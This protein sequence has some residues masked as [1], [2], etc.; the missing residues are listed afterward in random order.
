MYAKYT[1]CLYNVLDDYP[2]LLENL[3]MS[4]EE[5]TTR[6]KDTFVAMWFNYEIG[7]ET[8]GLFKLTLEQRFNRYKNYYEE[9]LDT[10][11]TNINFLDG[12]KSTRTISETNLKDD[13]DVASSTRALTRDE[14]KTLGESTT[15]LPRVQTANSIPSSKVDGTTEISDTTNDSVNYNNTKT[16]N[17]E[18]TLTE[19]KTGDENVIKL[20]V[21][22][23]NQIRN[24]YEEFSKE[25]KSC[26]IQ[27]FN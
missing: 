7:L 4:T 25:F 13:T 24:L 20:K 10:Y 2:N 8:I 23:M 1:S 16:I 17:E 22:Y 5:R 14:T 19:T 3:T 11:E 18:R 12:I 21:E 15:T 9:L 6:F 26:F 27:I